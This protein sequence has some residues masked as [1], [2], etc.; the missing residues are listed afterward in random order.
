MPTLNDVYRKF[1][2]V[3]EA[4]QLL[5]TQLGTMLLEARA[6]AAGLFDSPSPRDAR[7]ILD[8][9]NRNTLGQLLRQVSGFAKDLDQAADLLTRALVERNR[10]AHSFFRQHNFRRNSDSG[11]ALMLEDLESIHDTLIDAYKLVM[12]VSGFDLDRMLKG[13]LP[14]LPKQ[15]RNLD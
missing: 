5:E 6:Q 8:D 2:E 4:A 7:Q 9:V 13:E 14:E 12:R 10:L 11:C 3:S 1:G 15:H